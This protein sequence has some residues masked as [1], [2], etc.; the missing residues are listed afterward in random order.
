[1]TSSRQLFRGTILCAVRTL[2]LGLEY[3]VNLGFNPILAIVEDILS[4]SS[5]KGQCHEIFDP[6]FF[7]QNI[8]P[9]L[10]IKGLKPF[11]I[12]FEFAK[13]FEFFKMHAVSLTP[14]ARSTNDSN[15][16]GSL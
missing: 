12:K 2:T 3:T 6:R 9:G 4:D 11:L 5:L 1:M 16:P 14:H 8:R 7:H 10:L 15:G 13:I